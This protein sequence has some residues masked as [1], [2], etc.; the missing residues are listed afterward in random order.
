MAEVLQGMVLGDDEGVSQETT[1]AF[2]ASGLLHIMAVSGENVVLLCAMWSFAF[3]LLGLDRLVRTL[4]LLPLVAT[5]VLLTG[6]SPSI[7][8]AGVA[9]I[10][11]LL[12]VLASRPSDGWILW[13]APAAWLLTMNPDNLYDVSFQLS[14]AAVAG[15]LL[16]ARPLTLALA[17][18]PGPLPESVGVTTAASIS[19]APVSILTFG[20]ASLVSIPANALGGFVLGPIMFLGML[21]LLLGF[22]SEWV[23]APLNVVAGLFIGFLLAVSRLFAGLPGAVYTYQGV[24]LRWSRGPPGGGGGGGSAG[25]A[26]RRRSAGLHARPPPLAVAGSRD[27]GAAR[28]GASAVAGPGQAA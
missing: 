28:G 7:V 12:A 13:L 1:D 18:L 3:A 27:R 10:L 11:G 4:M 17:F 22:V 6:A 19:T 24:T 5:Y 25:D 8:R 14:F 9:G 20:S 2:R 15:L 23:S 21:S 26:V 16:I